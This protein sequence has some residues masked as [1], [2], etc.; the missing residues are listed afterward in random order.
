[1]RATRS[2]CWSSRRAAPRRTGS[3]R[4]LDLVPSEIH[5]HVPLI[6]GSPDKVQRVMELYASSVPQAGQR[7][8]F[9]TR[10][11]FRS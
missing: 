5:E 8:L 1:M 9:G 11:L 4:V 3:R 7:P 6:F 10:G 2:P